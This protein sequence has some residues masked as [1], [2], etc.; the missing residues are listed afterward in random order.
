MQQEYCKFMK[1]V[2]IF[3]ND[4]KP[5]LKF[6]RFRCCNHNFLVDTNKDSLV[7]TDAYIK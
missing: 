3:D 2:N 5:L 4:I 7:Q 6:K 1:T